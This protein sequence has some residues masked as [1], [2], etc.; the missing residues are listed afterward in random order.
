MALEPVTRTT[1][2]IHAQYVVDADGNRVSVLLPVAE[3]EKLR[4]DLDELYDVIALQEANAE[5]GEPI[6]WEVL[7]ADLD[8][9]LEC[10]TD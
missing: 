4:D 3:W 6:P 5:G 10:A 1:W 2:T 9:E 8:R 7:K